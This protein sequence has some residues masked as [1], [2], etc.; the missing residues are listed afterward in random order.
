[1]M[2]LRSMTIVFLGL[3]LL[4]ACTSNKANDRPDL[5]A[6]STSDASTE[7]ASPSPS[8]SES[9]VGSLNDYWDGQSKRRLLDTA[10]LDEEPPFEYVRFGLT[11]DNPEVR[12]YC[13]YRIGEEPSKID[14]ADRARLEAMTKDTDG[15]V[16]QAAQFTLQV[17]NGTFEG[18]AFSHSSD[19]KTVAFHRYREAR[20]NDGKVWLS[21]NGDTKVVYYSDASITNLS[22]SPDAAW[23][24]VEYGGRI[25]GSLELV[26]MK[27]AKPL[28]NTFLLEAV[29]KDPNGGY[30]D[31]DPS[32]N[33]RFDPYVRFLEWKSDG[34][35]FLFSYGFWRSAD[36]PEYGTAV[37]T[38]KTGTVSRIEKA[39]DERKHQKPE[40][41]AW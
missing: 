8:A 11:H 12:W 27:T 20:Y 14:E 21:R 40:N 22:I 38:I 23:L 30:T 15:N 16:R 10:I 33:D 19:N 5:Q 35:Q 29:L 31:V 2:R 39:A 7:T 3:V 17:L 25:W 1:M 41:F 13:A 32:Q 9:T 24:A 34:T 18:D 37:Y 36:R 6:S 28:G 26:D 4:T